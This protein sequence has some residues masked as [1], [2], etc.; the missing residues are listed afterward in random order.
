MIIL[1]RTAL[2]HKLEAETKSDC[3]EME[4]SNNGHCENKQSD[5]KKGR[6]RAR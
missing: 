2:W 3:G 1:S 5:S 4:G 6:E